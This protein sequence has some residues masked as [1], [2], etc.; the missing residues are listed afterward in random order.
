M[1]VKQKLYDI[2]EPA[3]KGLIHCSLS[4]IIVIINNLFTLLWWITMGWR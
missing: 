3:T 1:N 2:S 4:V